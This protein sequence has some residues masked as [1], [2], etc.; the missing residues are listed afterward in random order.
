MSPSL[1]PQMTGAW[2]NRA[3]FW[4][5]ALHNFFP[6]SPRYVGRIIL[7]LS[8]R[9]FAP[10]AG[11]SDNPM[12]EGEV[13]A[14]RARAAQAE[15]AHSNMIWIPGGTFRMGSDRHYPEEAPVHRVTLNGFW[16]DRTPVTNR[17]FRKF[18]NATG[19]ISFAEVP[20][21]PKDYPG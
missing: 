12:S 18:V 13:A 11:E 10:I 9:V 19:H 21:D 14:T 3:W 15:A 16:I 7:L 2:D 8:A 5:D 17:E 1:Q 4:R 20:P 6:H